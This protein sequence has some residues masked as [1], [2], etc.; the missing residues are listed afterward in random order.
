MGDEDRGRELPQRVRGARPGPQPAAPS[1]PALSDELRQRMQEAVKA[2]RAQ[3]AVQGQHGS[4][5]GDV[6]TPA[7]KQTNGHG[8]PRAQPKSIVQPEPVAEDGEPTEWLRR[9]PFTKTG[10]VVKPRPANG[11]KPADSRPA[12]RPQ[13]PAPTRTDRPT[14]PQPGGASP[15]PGRPKKP[16]RR[17]TGARLVTLVVL[18]IVV[19]SLGIA[20]VTYVARPPS[21]GGPPSA[22]RLRK[23]AVDRHQAAIWVAQ[24]VSHDVTVSCDKAMCAALEARGFP[25]RDLV[26]L[27]P[28]SPD[29]VPSVVVVETAAVRDLFGS[30]LAAAWAPAVLASFGSGPGGI[31][32]RVVASHGAAAYQA[33]L[34]ADL[35]ARKKNGASLLNDPQITLSTAARNELAAGQVDS[36]LVL[37]LAAL[38][39]RQ[40]ISIVEFGNIGPGVGLGIPLRFGDLAETDQAAHLTRSAYVRSVRGYLSTAD[41]QVRPAGTVTVVLPDGQA[42]LRVEFTAPSPLGVFGS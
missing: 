27:G 40:P 37:A 19:G 28:T 10:P 26:V 16:G 29:P 38:A 1:S 15:R 3:A 2:E 8:Q 31:T 32:V 7:V 5:G 18:I 39:S 9:E 35:T 14:P 41:A 22:A 30:S 11:L 4:A 36:R 20:A 34:R 25:A 17:R 21:G 42:V 13:A 24:Q 12:A 6:S 23:E 33:A